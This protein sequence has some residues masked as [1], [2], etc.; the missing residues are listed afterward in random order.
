MKHS[1]GRRIWLVFASITAPIWFPIALVI[2]AILFVIITSYEFG[3]YLVTGY[4]KHLDTI[5]Y[6][7]Y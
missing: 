2:F 7:L 5:K 1:I 4:T 3:C 6:G